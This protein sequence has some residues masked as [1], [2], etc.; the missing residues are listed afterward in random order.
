M[1]SNAFVLCAKCQG[2][3]PAIECKSLDVLAEIEPFSLFCPSCHEGL[4]YDAFLVK[5]LKNP[6]LYE[7]VREY[8]YHYLREL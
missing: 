8:M 4:N 6:E 1:E 3:F 5:L 2:S 7:K